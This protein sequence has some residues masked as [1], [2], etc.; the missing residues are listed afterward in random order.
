MVGG[1]FSVSDTELVNLRRTD[2][3]DRRIDR[4][5]EFGNPFRLEE[6]G[7]DYSREESVKEYRKWFYSRIRH[8]DEFERK[9]KELKGCTLACWCTPK[10]C[11]GDVILEYLEEEVR[12]L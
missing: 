2:Q 12:S 1:A 10:K 4:S 11:Y 3:F 7:G 5:S 9:V 6:D 8:D